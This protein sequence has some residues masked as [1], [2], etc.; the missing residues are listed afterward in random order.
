MQARP[1]RREFLTRPR[2]AI[3]IVLDGVDHLPN[4]GS[5]FRLCDAFRV[6]RLHVCGFELKPHK[7][8]FVRAAS[9]TI[10]WVPWENSGRAVD[11][12]RAKKDEGYVAVAIEMA[13]GSVPPHAMRTDSRLCLVVGAER[14][15]VSDDVLKLVDQCVEIPT[16]GI[17][18]SINLASAAAIVLY[19]AARRFPLA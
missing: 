1:D 19:E 10:P 18:G 14:H 6:E 8:S 16:D 7:R 12:V 3:C 11:V 15:G 2:R 17:G 13:D 4:L 9:G 5:I